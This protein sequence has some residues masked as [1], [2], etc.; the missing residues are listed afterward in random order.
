[1]KRLIT[2]IKDVRAIGLY[3]RINKNTNK[4]IRVL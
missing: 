4:Q 2:W 3:I 1:M